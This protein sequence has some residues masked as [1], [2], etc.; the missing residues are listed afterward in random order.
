LAK[1]WWM[2]CWCMNHRKRLKWWIKKNN[3]LLNWSK[4]QAW[5]F[6][7]IDTGRG[8]NISLHK[9]DFETRRVGILCTSP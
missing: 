3:V 7:S 1:A 6:Q 9:S 8:Y 5:I 2:I 4:L